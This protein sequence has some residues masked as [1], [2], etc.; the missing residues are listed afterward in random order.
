MQQIRGP[1]RMITIQPVGRLIQA[2]LGGD[3]HM[4]VRL[5]DL[6]F[7]PLRRGGMSAMCGFVFG[8]KLLDA[9]LLARSLATV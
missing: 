3:G 4:A 7:D 9:P 6:I 2:V 1:P 8:E 5:F